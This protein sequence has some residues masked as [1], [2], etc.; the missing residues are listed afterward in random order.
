MKLQYKIMAYF[1]A[2]L[3]VVIGGL[4]IL[5]FQHLTSSLETQMGNNAM[6]LAVT[7]AAIDDIQRALA[8]KEPYDA[9]QNYV[10]SF[11]SKTRFQYIIVM[12]MDGIQYSYPYQAG[13][14]KSYKN[15]GEDRVLSDGASYVSADRN[16]LI[17]AIRAFTPVYYNGKQVGAVLVGLL[18]DQV[19]KENSA[20]RLSLEKIIIVTAILGIAGAALLSYN[21]KVSIY[22]LEPK[23]IAILLGQRDL[24]LQSMVRGIIAIDINGK[25]ILYNPSAQKT[26]NLSNDA[27]GKNISDYNIKFAEEMKNALSADFDEY[28]KEIRISPSKTLLTSSCLMRDRKKG[29]IGIVSSFE[30]LTEA[31]K[32]AEELTGYRS[33]VNALRAQNHEF[34][35]KLHTI[36]GLVQLEEYDKA[37]DYIDKI[38]EDRALISGTIINRIKNTYVAAIL[39]AKYNK[40]KE[41]KVSLIV[42]QNS[43]L[44]KELHGI[45]ED[46]L[47]SVIGNLIDNAQEALIDEEGGTVEV[48]I[49][50]SKEALELTVKDNGKGIKEEIVDKVFESGITTKQGSRGMGLFIVKNIIDQYQGTIEYKYENGLIWSVRIPNEFID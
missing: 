37:I 35:N 9:V 31:K 24:I 32:M 18:T 39:L 26:F 16:V 23:E 13:L 47:C 41:A 5:V 40:L 6:D 45:R 8:N 21:I 10:E 29:V 7:V 14:G 42:N 4:S 36:S 11:R 1:S 22:G 12:D 49:H 48:Y 20:N 46:E 50:D 43:S 3:I 15:G 44:G 30:D 2:V 25:I 17:S 27:V 28:N 34:M 38:T 19:N 33:L